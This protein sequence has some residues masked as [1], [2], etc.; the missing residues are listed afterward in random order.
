MNGSGATGSPT[1][2]RFGLY[3]RSGTTMTLVARTANDTNIFSAADTK[4]TRTLD[5]TGGYPASYT[6]NAGTDYWVAVIF[7]GTTA[8]TIS[9]A[10]DRSAAN[11]ATGPQQYSKATQTDL[12]AT[13]TTVTLAASLAG[14]YAELS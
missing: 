14:F 13:V 8:P 1:T 12:G 7:V 6:V 11:A 4:Y 5:T 2:V 3:T 9:Q 10:L